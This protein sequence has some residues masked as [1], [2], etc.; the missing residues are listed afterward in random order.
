MSKIVKLIQSPFTSPLETVEGI[1]I[2]LHVP[3]SETEVTV[4]VDSNIEEYI[5]NDDKEDIQVRQVMVNTDTPLTKT[6]S[7]DFNENVEQ[8]VKIENDNYKIKLMNIGKE[9]LQGQDFLF[10]EFNV[11]KG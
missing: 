1:T 6:L 3:Y 5:E 10:Y 7:F 9:N 4:K 2:Q 8:Q 11:I